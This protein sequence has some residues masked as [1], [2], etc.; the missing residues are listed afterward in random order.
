MEI[1]PIVLRPF[2]GL[3]VWCKFFLTVTDDLG[4][5]LGP[6]VV[7][8]VINLVGRRSA[9]NIATLGSEHRSSLAGSNSGKNEREE[10]DYINSLH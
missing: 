3:L 10:G 5:G 6:A 4:K 7:A 8:V 9:F 1:Y 2:S